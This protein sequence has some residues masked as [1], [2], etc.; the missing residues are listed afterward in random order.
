MSFE[1]HEESFVKFL[2]AESY[3][4]EFL[5]NPNDVN[6]W[7]KLEESSAENAWAKIRV[8]ECYLNGS[9][10][11]TTKDRE[12]AYKALDKLIQQGMV[13]ARLKKAEYILNDKTFKK[14]KRKEAKNI[15][16]NLPLLFAGD[17]RYVLGCH[18]LEK[19]KT[20]KAEEQ[21]RLALKAGNMEAGEKL[22]D[23]KK[24][25]QSRKK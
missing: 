15:L 24:Q 18:Y 17:G 2:R 5:S 20:Q 3:F 16:K 6:A 25:Q 14:K 13:F 8:A 12:Q 9:M 23:L 22:T 10:K 19:D 1:Y 4:R 7:E 11:A 21:F